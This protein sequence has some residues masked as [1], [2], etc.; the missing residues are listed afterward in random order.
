[1]QPFRW[2]WGPTRRGGR[3]RPPSRLRHDRKTGQ[4]FKKI[5]PRLSFSVFSA[6]K[7]SLRALRLCVENH[8][9]SKTGFQSLELL[10]KL[11]SNH[12]KNGQT[13]FQ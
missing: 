6:L 2:A 10:P 11:G 12:W 9:V 8:S 4:L 1:M 7:N 13:G 3:G 5:S